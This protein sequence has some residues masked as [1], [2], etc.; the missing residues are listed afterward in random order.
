[1]PNWVLDTEEPKEEKNKTPIKY[2]WQLDIEPENEEG[3]ES[4]LK[5]LAYAPFRIGKDLAV[6]GWQGAQKIPQLYQQGKTEI[7]GLINPLSSHPLHRAMQGLAGSQEAI[8]LLNHLPA[9]LAQYANERLHL[10]PKQVPNFLNKITPDTTQA[11]NELFDQPKYPGEALL[12]AG[13]RN[14]PNIIPAVKT[15]NMLNPLNLTA[16]IVAKNVLKARERNIGNYGNYYKD[17]WKEAEGKGFGDALYNINID[18]PTIA[19]YSPKKG[20]KGVLDFDANPTLENAHNAKSDLLRIKRDLDKQTTL[21]T[22]ER[23]QLH[24][25]N[26][27][28]DSINGNMFKEPGGQV[29]KILADKYAKIQEGYKN[30][31]IP[32]KNKAINEFLK[33]ESSA[34]ELVNSLSKKAFYAKRGKYHNDLRLR[35]LFQKYPYLAPAAAG[36]VLGA[37]GLGVYEKHLKE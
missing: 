10:L 1:M 8:N 23:Q 6:A 27:A 30:E 3:D 37:G 15:A 5:S 22:A 26:N 7:P 29:N 11:I 36:A 35:K 12:R 34:E 4:I 17:L 19:K 13:I 33:G 18:I 21:R 16:K 9:N 31:V 14:L 28:I 25:V 20:I 32:Y 24:A 2:N